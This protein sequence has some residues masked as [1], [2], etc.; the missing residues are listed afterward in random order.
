[1]LE[2]LYFRKN[3]P[4]TYIYKLILKIIKLNINIQNFC[5]LNCISLNTVYNL[6]NLTCDFASK[7]EK[8]NLYYVIY[9]YLPPKST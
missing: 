9:F 7:F 1:M 8:I 3:I 6:Y 4:N 2:I 5:F